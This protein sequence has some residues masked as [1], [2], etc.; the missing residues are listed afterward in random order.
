MHDGHVTTAEKFFSYRFLY[1]YFQMINAIILKL[2]GFCILIT[3]SE[4]HPVEEHVDAVSQIIVDNDVG[5]EL[6]RSKRA[7]TPAVKGLAAAKTLLKGAKDAGT[8]AEYHAY[9][10]MGN[11]QTAVTDFRSVKPT[12]TVFNNHQ[13]YG[14]PRSKALEYPRYVGMVGDR[15]IILWLQGDRYS[16][17]KPVLEISSATGDVPDRIT[18]GVG[19]AWYMQKYYRN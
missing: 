14:K 2:A 7:V 15:R 13:P 9:K 6:S 3:Q 19:R 12:F 4:H 1:L 8:R 17:G 5:H 10:K 16:K 11:R 18:Y